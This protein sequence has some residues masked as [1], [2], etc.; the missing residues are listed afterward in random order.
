M[1]GT[2]RE[3]KEKWSVTYW[4]AY[5]GKVSSTPLGSL[6]PFEKVIFLCSL[7][8][9]PSA[10]GILAGVRRVKLRISTYQKPRE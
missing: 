10:K 8:E 6:R 5:M 3:G 2:G 1:V 9:R 4:A 7:R